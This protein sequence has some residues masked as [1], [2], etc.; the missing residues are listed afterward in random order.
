MTILY[1]LFEVLGA[2]MFSGFCVGLL[3]IGTTALAF[4]LFEEPK[5][6]LRG[7]II[8]SLTIGLSTIMLIIR[9]L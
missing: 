9:Y 8:E 1:F 6:E 2:L 7:G 4:L 3:L 5:L